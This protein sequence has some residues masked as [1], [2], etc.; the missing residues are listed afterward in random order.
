MRL[1]RSMP[2]ADACSRDVWAGIWHALIAFSICRLLL[3]LIIT[4]PAFPASNETSYQLSTFDFSRKTLR[5]RSSLHMRPRRC[6]LTRLS[7]LPHAEAGLGWLWSR[8]NIRH[9]V[10]H[11]YHLSPKCWGDGSDFGS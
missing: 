11:I 6:R 1:S 9:S 7:Q 3:S 2:L 4:L 8:V 10:V 5:F